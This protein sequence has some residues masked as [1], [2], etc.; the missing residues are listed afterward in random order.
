MFFSGF[1]QI[2]DVDLIATYWPDMPVS[3]FVITF[4]SLV[5]RY[6]NKNK[7]CVDRIVFFNRGGKFLLSTHD[8]LFSHMD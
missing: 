4:L 5:Y 2:G 6:L 1:W 7:G 3:T 8:G